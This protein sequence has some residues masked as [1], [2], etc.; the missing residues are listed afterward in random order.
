[1][2]RKP[3]NWA[4]FTTTRKPGTRHPDERPPRPEVLPTIT[5][6]ERQR[7]KKQDLTLRGILDACDD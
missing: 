2:E 4:T 3:P 7:R 6:K 5:E 1:M